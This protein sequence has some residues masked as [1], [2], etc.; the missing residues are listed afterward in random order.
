MTSRFPWLVGLLVLILGSVSGTL[1]GERPSA[2]TAKPQPPVI[3]L[4]HP[5]PGKPATAHPVLIRGTIEPPDPDVRVTVDGRPTF[6]VQGGH[7]VTLRP[8]APGTHVLLLEARARGRVVSS[9]ERQVTVAGPVPTR[10]PLWSTAGTFW[11]GLGGGRSVHLG[12]P[13]FVWRFR[14]EPAGGVTTGQLDPDGSGRL[15]RVLSPRDEVYTHEFHTTGIYGPTLRFTDPAG[16]EATQ[17][18]LVIIYDRAWLEPILQAR[19]AELQAALARGNMGEVLAHIESTRRHRLRE[20]MEV[21]PM[22]VDRLIP[23]ESGPFV[24]EKLAGELAICLVGSSSHRVG[25][26]VDQRDGLWRVAWIDP[27]GWKRAP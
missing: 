21:F 5:E 25:F 17:Q 12:V 15:I 6:M 8:L 3:R 11:A 9:L 10:W 23:R 18:G 16:Y 19:W 20:E 27:D 1:A 4:L 22:R 14:F 24:L 26:A 13:P 2:A 7:W